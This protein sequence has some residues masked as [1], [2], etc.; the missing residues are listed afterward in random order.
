MTAIPSDQSFQGHL[1]LLMSG[2]AAVGIQALMLSPLM[3]DIARALAAGPVE[4]G[5]ASGAYG[6]GVALSALLAAPRLGQWPKRRAIQIAFAV[7]AAGLMLC[8]SAFDWR[9][10][11]FGQFVTG[12]AAGVI[13]PGTYALTADLTPDHMRSRAI[14]RVITGW[15]VAMVAGIPFAALIADLLSWRGTF[16]IVAALAAVMIF[17]I[18]LLPRTEA[19]AASRPVPYAQALAVKGI[20]L[21]LFATFVNMIAFYQTYTFIGDHVRHVHDAGAWLGGLFA[22]SY[23]IGFGLAVFFDGWI[24]RVG[25]S[26]LMAASLFVLGINYILLPLATFNI[27]TAIAYPVVWG[28]IQHVGMNT[29][30]SYIG[31]APQAERSTAMGLFSFV[32]YVAVGLGGAAY[33]SVYAAHGI[34]ANTIA[35]TLTLW[36][37]AAVVFLLMPKVKAAA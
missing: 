12:L 37:G 21:V 36:I 28:L 20:P 10:L 11:V 17:G 18:G 7:M 15:S 19:S 13:I 25:P 35:A 34:F 16:I 22:C 32:T 29:L 6:V 5:I 30:V 9:L 1:L 8:A 27:A 14:G 4:V 24:D 31:A 26:R 23:G 2:I 33:G 3:P